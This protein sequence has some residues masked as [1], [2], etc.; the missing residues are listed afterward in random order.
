MDQ[1]K[2]DIKVI[3]SSQCGD[4]YRIEDGKDTQSIEVFVEDGKVE[5]IQNL[6]S[7]VTPP[8]LN[9]EVKSINEESEDDDDG[10]TPLQAVAKMLDIPMTK[11]EDGSTV[12]LEEIKLGRVVGGAKYSDRKPSRKSEM[13]DG[14]ISMLGDM[15]GASEVKV[16]GDADKMPESLKELLSMLGMKRGK[17]TPGCD[18]D[19]CKKMRDAT[20]ND[21]VH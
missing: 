12:Y 13:I 11:Q 1:F 9:A 4:N 8:F 6:I 10:Y 2:K 17:P 20:D 5:K 16:V 15:G 18:C 14:I 19:N 7:M 3:L 21:Q